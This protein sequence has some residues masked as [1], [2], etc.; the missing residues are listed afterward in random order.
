MLNT[1]A[2]FKGVF[3]FMKKM[4]DP[5][6]FAKIKVFKPSSKRHKIVAYLG[7]EVSLPRR[8]A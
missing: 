5:A 4:L 7:E 1:P 2:L 6:T 8:L 3:A